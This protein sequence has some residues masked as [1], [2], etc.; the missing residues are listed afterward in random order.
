VDRVLIASHV[1]IFSVPQK[2]MSIFAL[3]QIVGVSENLGVHT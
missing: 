3:A 2:E 1:R